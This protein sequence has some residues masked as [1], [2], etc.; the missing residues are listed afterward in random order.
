LAQEFKESPQR[1]LTTF[2]QMSDADFADLIEEVNYH[3]GSLRALGLLILGKS[4]DARAV[5]ALLARLTGEV[6]EPCHPLTGD[7][8]YSIARRLLP[9]LRQTEQET[10]SIVRVLDRRGTATA[11]GELGAPRS[12]DALRSLL[13]D[14][15]E[16]VRIAAQN[17]LV[18]LRGV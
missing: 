16:W 3:G 9:W 5:D 7:W 12:A 2:K 4:G 14:R 6:P 1:L 15:D 13:D 18:R 8:R 11:L 17:A 10:R